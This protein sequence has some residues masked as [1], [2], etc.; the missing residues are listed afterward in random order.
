MK[1]RRKLL[2]GLVA[3][4]VG[5]TLT[6]QAVAPASAA[7]PA[8]APA[9]N[10]VL[11]DSAEAPDLSRTADT[12]RSRTVR[13]QVEQDPAGPGADNF[14][15][16]PTTIWCTLEAFSP[17]VALVATEIEATAHG[18]C[19]WPMPAMVVG[20]SLLRGT[21]EVSSTTSTGFGKQ[22][23]P[24]STFGPCQSGTYLTAATATIFAP[25][26]Y[27]P[28]FRQF[29][30]AS[31]PAPIVSAGT[32]L[33]PLVCQGSGSQPPPPPP[34][35]G[36]PS[37]GIHCEFTGNNQFICHLSTSNWTQIRWFVNSSP[38]SAWNNQTTVQGTCS[39]GTR[40][41]VDVSN[42]S[43]TTSRTSFIDCSGEPR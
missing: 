7:A 25:A 31:V 11:A 32:P 21:S 19:T 27:S 22:S 41:D 2:G 33:P 37:V 38:R 42:S 1:L 4:M 23:F 39:G 14:T 24:V 40:I 35:P 30:A 5:G 6:V 18:V 8:P 29:G 17:H 28:A 3:A 13:F 20:V 43:G 12:S 36:G 34:P 16:P 10:T 9:A 26:G 15:G